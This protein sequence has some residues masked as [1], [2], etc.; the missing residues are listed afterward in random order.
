[1]ESWYVTQPQPTMNSGFEN[2]EWDNYV[3]NA[4]DEVLTET[5]LG[6]TVLLCNGL[7]NVETGEFETEFET[8]AVVQNVTPDTY[9]QGWKRQILTRIS[10]SL[11]NYKYVKIKDTKD[12]W[13]IYLIMTMPDTNQIYTKS[14]IHEC[15]Y[16]LRWQDSETGDIYNYPCF[17]EDASQYNSGVENTNSVIRTTYNQL[18]CW[19]SFDDN[20]IG[21]KRDRRMFIDYSTAYPP[22]VYEI[23]STSKV[24]YSYN[25]NRIMRLLFTETEYNPD[26]DHIDLLLCDYVDPNDIPQPTTPIN[27]EYNGNPEVKI[28]GR[29]TF[30][31]VSENTVTFSLVL[32]TILTNK[33]TMEQAD[34]QCVV[35]VVNDTLIVGSHFKLVAS[36]SGE[37]SE[38]LITIKGVV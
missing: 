14:P 16:T 15:N 10:D 9:T 24:P 3:L 8:Q 12:E 22:E 33:V 37:Q 7:Y 11:V 32:D 20:T 23:T 19:I 27:I 21:L 18:M 34:N 26:T 36:M 35:R 30:K 1:M 6:Q 31:V 25:D 13:Q 17:I 28:G 38:L 29:K 2:E 4:F 5:K